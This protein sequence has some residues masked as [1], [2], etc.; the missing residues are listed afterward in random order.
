[1]T[2]TYTTGRRYVLLA[3][4]LSCHH[5]A[6]HAFVVRQSGSY[7]L[8]RRLAFTIERH[9]PDAAAT[10]RYVPGNIIYKHLRTSVASLILC[11]GH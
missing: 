7:G 10:A 6:S 8:P 9:Q 5:P 2:S 3:L 4:L 11:P 1:M